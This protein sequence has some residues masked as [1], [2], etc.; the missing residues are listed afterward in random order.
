[1]VA[2]AETASRRSDD[3]VA[4]EATTDQLVP[5]KCSISAFSGVLVFVSA[6]DEPTAQTSVVVIADTP[7]KT[8]LPDPTLSGVEGVQPV[9]FHLAAMGWSTFDTSKPPPTAKV[10]LT[11]LLEPG[12]TLTDQKSLSR[13]EPVFVFELSTLDQLVP[14]QW[15]VSVWS[16]ELVPPAFWPPTAQI[17]FGPAAARLLLKM[18]SKIDGLAPGTTWN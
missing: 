17:S 5:S 9:P 4:G 3:V 12:T 1:M 18:A 13:L 6:F 10:L 8:L 14:F 16:G 7:S 2:L 15:S 11:L